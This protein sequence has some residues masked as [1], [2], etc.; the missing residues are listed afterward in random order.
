MTEFF[1]SLNHVEI[2]LKPQFLFKVG[3]YI[4]PRSLSLDS[5]ICLKF[6]V[7]D[8]SFHLGE[9]WGQT[10]LPSFFSEEPGENKLNAV[11]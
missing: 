6:G 10:P 1:Q 7:V 3:Y 9:Q 8:P 5:H 11:S 4:L 2:N